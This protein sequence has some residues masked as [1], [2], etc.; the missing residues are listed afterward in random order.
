[1]H[2][3]F[4]A[5]ILSWPKLAKRT[6]FMSLAML[7][8]SGLVVLRSTDPAPLQTVRDVYFDYLQALAPRDYTPLPVVIVDLDEESIEKL[9]QWPWPRYRLAALLDRLGELG[10]AVVAFDI[11][12]SEADR[13]SAKN[14]LNDVYVRDALGEGPWVKR[15][16]LIDNDLVFAEAMARTPTVL[17]VA[18]AGAGHGGRL[19][20]KA[21]FALIG[22][23]PGSSLLPLRSATNTVPA[24]A[25]AAAGIGVINVNPLEDSDRIRESPLVW[26]TDQGPVPGLALE[27][28]RVALGETTVVVR[29]SDDGPN[30]IE[31][32]RVGGYSIPTTTYG[33]FQLHFRHDVSAQ[34]IPAFEVL[35]PV[36]SPE[37]QARLNG[38]IVFVGTSAAGLADTRT[39]ALGERVPGVS[40]HAQIVEQVLL[41]EYLT[42]TDVSEGA[43]VLL[44][45]FLS[46]I[47]VIVLMLNGPILSVLVG[48]VFAAVSLG[49][50]WYAYTEMGVLFDATFPLIGGFFIF[51][52]LAMF[53]Y[54]I[55]DREKRLLRRSFAHYV[56]PSIL[57]EMDRKG[58]RLEIGGKM[59][60]VTVMF[61]DIRNFTP[62]AAR[63]S[64]QDLV[65]L[66]NELFTDLSHEILA[67]SG[68]I[69]KYI[70]DEIMAFWNAPLPIVDH[71]LRACLA[72]LQM[73]ACLA[74][75]NARK[76]SLGTPV[77]K[78]AIGL[79]FGNA[80]VGNIG[81][82]NHFNYTAIGDTVNIAS[83]TQ[84][85]CR[86]VGHDILVTADVARLASSLA[87]LPA[88]R[89]DL[90]GVSD[91]TEVLILVG[92]A[93]RATSPGFKQAAIEF[94]NLMN[95]IK[96]GGD[97]AFNMLSKVRT[98]FAS[99]DLP[100]DDF[101]NRCMQRRDDF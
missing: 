12:F 78:V 58:H 42:R 87:F 52:A 13:L 95:E 33:M 30:R 28:L 74:R 80:C 23:D 15:L 97:Q 84:T 2:K 36:L 82:L 5:R 99:I 100:L 32:I 31:D 8:L 60:E 20:S 91:R 18:D 44:F 75:Y 46:L 38:A 94:Q 76:A 16:S 10:A 45:I 17:G 24:L 3:D 64:A 61:C 63:M 88:G 26:Q 96:A 14:L 90:K 43:E 85:A 65:A 77:V 98:Y 57:D 37:L 22:Q 86:H 21:G 81:S 79:D 41:E 39:T 72:A 70:G 55:A 101:L 25:V 1:M 83:R 19:L 89:I 53:Q 51:S 71:Q 47:V 50:S 49:G 93:D 68:T 6:S 35:A 11:L 29:G 92:D 54:G 66:L 7:L 4:L 59:G 34:Y 73:R 27:A 48:A 62:M 9:G 69:D 56:A 67:Q 40:I